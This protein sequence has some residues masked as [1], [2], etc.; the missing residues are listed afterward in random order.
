MD[1][2]TAERITSFAQDCVIGSGEGP[3]WAE[4]GV[5]PDADTLRALSRLLG[6][7]LTGE[8]H[9]VFLAAWKVCLMECAHP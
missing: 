2:L 8:E 1:K 5:E 9:S 7:P 4:L 3:E 6:H